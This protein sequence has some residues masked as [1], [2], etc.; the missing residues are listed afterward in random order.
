MDKDEHRFQNNMISD[1]NINR[2][3]MSATSKERVTNVLDEKNAKNERKDM[4]EDK[5]LKPK[6]YMT[7]NYY[8]LHVKKIRVG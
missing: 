1:E 6:K 3:R 8:L 4:N 2:T 5:W 7:I